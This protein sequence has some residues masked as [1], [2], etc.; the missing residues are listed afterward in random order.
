[1]HVTSLRK[2]KRIFN[3]IQVS[4]INFAVQQMIHDVHG[5]FSQL[6]V[7]EL[8]EFNN[9]NVVQL[10]FQLIHVESSDDLRDRRHIDLVRVSHFFHFLVE[11]LQEVLSNRQV[12]QYILVQSQV[13]VVLGADSFK[14]GLAHKLTDGVNF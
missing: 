2:G 8:T 12:N 11:H 14:I 4:E 13:V 10:E 6:R 5:S 3:D 1:M 7:A 9:P